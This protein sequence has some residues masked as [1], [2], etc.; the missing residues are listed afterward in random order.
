[1]HAGDVDIDG[2]TWIAGEGKLVLTTANAQS[3]A[4]AAA[5]IER[6]GPE[7]IRVLDLKSCSATSVPWAELAKLA[8]LEELNVEGDIFIDRLTA[9][10]PE[11]GRLAGLRRLLASDNELTSLPAGDRA[12]R[13]PGGVVRAQQQ[14]GGAAR[15]IGRLTHLKKLD[16]SRNELTALPPEIGKLV[17]L[18]ELSLGHNGLTSLPA[19]IRQLVNLQLLD[20]EFYGSQLPPE[21]VQLKML[22]VLNLKYF[23]SM[24][25]SNTGT[26]A[27]LAG[28]ANLEE[29]NVA[30]SG[31][32]ALQ[33]RLDCSYTSRSCMQ[34]AIR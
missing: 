9:L 11:I 20:L 24:I 27:A 31:L 2:W 29:L 16:V 15:E 10:P 32:P 28:L 8:N 7:N 14:A 19:E 13:K 30:C 26:W 34:M 25:T 5:A 6:A 3:A 17:N 4:A 12:A 1:M 23:S 18:V 33:R 21:F 22:R